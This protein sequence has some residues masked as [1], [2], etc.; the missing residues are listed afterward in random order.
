MNIRTKTN[1]I[2]IINRSTTGFKQVRDILVA[3]GYLDVTHEPS[4]EAALR[5]C[6]VPEVAER[7]DLAKAPYDLIMID[8]SNLDVDGLELCAR[9]R[10]NQSTR[11]V[12]ILIQ[13]DPI[14]VELLNQAYMAGVDDF[15]INP[16]NDIRLYARVRT[17]LRMR[18]EQVRK[19]M[20]E[21]DL[22]LQNLNL[23]Q[24]KIEAAL[25]DPV[26]GLP[27][28]GVVE[29]VLNN[30]RQEGYA[31]ALAIMQIIDFDLYGELHGQ[32]EAFRLRKRISKLLGTSPGPLS[33]LLCAYGPGTFMVV[34]PG[35]ES[36]DQLEALSAYVS[37]V[38][39]QEKIEHGN[40]ISDQ[41]VTLYTNCT[42]GTGDDLVSLTGE[43]LQSARTKLV[44]WKNDA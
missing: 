35:A 11:N 8:L 19:E 42:W 15:V 31:A 21:A 17:L 28:D 13:S 9:I 4:G 6:G 39:S 27:K 1:R 40:S 7:E 22:R 38:V 20:R 33:S 30:C 16:V 24:G 36:A 43:L 23:K 14:D 41:N 12:P 29:L 34:Q 18:R 25:I 3:G 2:L 26:V 10:V 5:M 32:D 44:E 37:K